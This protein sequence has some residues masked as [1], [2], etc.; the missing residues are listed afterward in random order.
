[1][2]CRLLL[3]GVLTGLLL[4]CSLASAEQVARVVET[5]A[6]PVRGVVKTTT[7][8]YLGIPY[9]EPPVGEWRWRPPRPK[10]PWKAV[11]DATQYRDH[12]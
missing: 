1:M 10:R 6:G 8:S 9:A 2:F 12:W 7:V 4:I 11:L 5:S 3:P